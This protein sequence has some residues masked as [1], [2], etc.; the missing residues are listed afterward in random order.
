MSQEVDLLCLKDGSFNTPTHPIQ[1]CF[2]LAQEKS[3]LRE[4]G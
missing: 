3:P 2:S 4:N 1:S